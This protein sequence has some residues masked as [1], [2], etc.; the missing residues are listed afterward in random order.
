MS[1]NKR[2]RDVLQTFVFLCV[3]VTHP[4]P[5]TRTHLHPQC[6]HLEW[7]ETVRKVSPKNVETSMTVALEKYLQAN[8]ILP[9]VKD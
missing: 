3:C 2:M 8:K 5:P 7:A 4:H 1:L 6:L 9:K